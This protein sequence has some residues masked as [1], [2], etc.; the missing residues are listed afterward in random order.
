MNRRETVGSW[1]QAFPTLIDNIKQFSKSLYNL[2]ILQIGV[3]I[4]VMPQT[5]IIFLP[6]FF[7]YFFFVCFRN[8]ALTVMSNDISFWFHLHFPGA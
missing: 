6:F 7:L 5:V 1:V 4:H 8:L 2:H 3:N